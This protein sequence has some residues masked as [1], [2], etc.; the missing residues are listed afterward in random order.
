MTDKF[1]D[2]KDPTDVWDYAIDYSALLDLSSP[3]D[4]INTSAWSVTPSGL[5]I[6]SDSIVL[7]DTAVVWVSG[8]GNLETIHK[9]TNH[10]VTIG[11]REID[12][13]IEITIR[14]T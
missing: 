6:D 8:G 13:T 11:G 7:P 9:L 14:H 5:T 12:R 2:V 1:E 3:A 10:I 4:Q